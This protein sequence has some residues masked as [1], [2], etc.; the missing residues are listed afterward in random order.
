MWTTLWRCTKSKKTTK[1]QKLEFRPSLPIFLSKK[2]P[3]FARPFTKMSPSEELGGKL[4]MDI[5]VQG[6]SQLQCSIIGSDMPS[7]LG[8]VLKWGAPEC[9]FEWGACNRYLGSAQLRAR[10]QWIIP[11]YR[12]VFGYKSRHEALKIIFITFFFGPSSSRK[13]IYS[14]KWL[15]QAAAEG[16]STDIICEHSIEV[17]CE[18]WNI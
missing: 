13:T 15:T 6:N 18:W 1:S 8:L 5:V 9:L 10:E 3:S 4:D 11:Q 16:I 17:R 14:H 12:K 7:A 2:C